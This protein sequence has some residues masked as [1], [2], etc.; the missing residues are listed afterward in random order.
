MS[1][2]QKQKQKREP[3]QISNSKDLYATHCQYL[4]KQIE[5]ITISKETKNMFF[6]KTKN[7]KTVLSWFPFF[8]VSKDKPKQTTAIEKKKLP[9]GTQLPE[10]INCIMLIAFNYCTSFVLRIS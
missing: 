7:G 2:V 8:M 1:H 5:H 3:K 4:N 9:K 10:I 6:F